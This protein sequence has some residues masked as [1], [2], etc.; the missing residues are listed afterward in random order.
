[1]QSIDEIKKAIE[2]KKAA[3]AA[4]A[5]EAAE[6]HEAAYLAAYLTALDTYD[7]G[8]LV[9]VDVPR[10]GKCLLR[11]AGRPDHAQFTKAIHE[12]IEVAPCLT[13]AV[14]CAVFPAPLDFK[15]LLEAKN[16]E[17]FVD[18]ALAVKNAMKSR[19]IEE[20]KE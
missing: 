17:G 2:A 19:V 9:T 6:K 18:C 12:K 10:V 4:P 16:P 13:F 20:G 7:E 3:K 15:T 1:M 8:E 5:R 14:K 11:F